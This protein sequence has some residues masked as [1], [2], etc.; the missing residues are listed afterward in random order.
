MSTLEAVAEALELCGE[1]LPAAQLRSLHGSVLRRAE[2][3]R[4]FFPPR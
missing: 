4:G 1:P 2:R 3:L